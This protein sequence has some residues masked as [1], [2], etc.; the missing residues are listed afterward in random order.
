MFVLVFT[1]S[2][3]V[4]L[5]IIGTSKFKI[6]RVYCK[7][8]THRPPAQN[9]T[10]KYLVCLFTHMDA[11]CLYKELIY[12]FAQG[13]EYILLQLALAFFFFF[14]WTRCLGEHSIPP[15]MGF[16]FTAATDGLQ[17][18]L[19]TYAVRLI[20]SGRIPYIFTC[21]LYFLKAY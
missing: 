5:I 14:N 12:S 8:S 16:L 20:S 6:H 13:T 4:W 1:F 21:A 10:V 3:F 11:P 9:V 7:A 19:I 15:L 2:F 17:F 18:A